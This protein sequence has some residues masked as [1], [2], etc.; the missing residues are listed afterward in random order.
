MKVRVG[1]G[2]LGHSEYLKDKGSVAKRGNVSGQNSLY[3]Q[4]RRIIK[5]KKTQKVLIISL[6]GPGLF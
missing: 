2:E 3:K 4:N 5:W 6:L 1:R